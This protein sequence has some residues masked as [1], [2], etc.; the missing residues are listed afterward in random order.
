[1]KHLLN[2]SIQ[3]SSGSAEQSVVAKRRRAKA[4]KGGRG[5]LGW[6]WSFVLFLCDILI[7][8]KGG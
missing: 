8:N 7:L 6:F 3:G 4:V 1:M 2:A 5:D